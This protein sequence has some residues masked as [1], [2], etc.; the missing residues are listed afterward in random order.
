MLTGDHKLQYY[1]QNQSVSMK[2]AFA[3]DAAD[4]F[5]LGLQDRRLVALE[6]I[7]VSY[8]STDSQAKVKDMLLKSEFSGRFEEAEIMSSKLAG[9]LVSALWQLQ[10]GSDPS[11]KVFTLRE[12]SKAEKNQ[13]REKSKAGYI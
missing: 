3:D 1:A 6:E 7:D 11:F 12:K 10:F 8:A 13:I 4:L 5:R 2:R 9:Q